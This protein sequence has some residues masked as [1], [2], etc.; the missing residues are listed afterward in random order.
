MRWLPT[1]PAPPVTSATFGAG[2]SRALGAHGP[3]AN[4][5]R[6]L[7]LGSRGMPLDERLVDQFEGDGWVVL[8]GVLDAD[9]IDRA[10]DALRA[11]AAASEARG[12]PTAMDYLDPGGRNVRV[13][14]L[15]EYR[16]VFVDLVAHPG[17]IP[18]VAR[19]L[20]DDLA[21]SNFSANIALPGS[22]SMNAHND[23]STVMPEPWI[24]PVHDERDLVP[25]RHRRGQRRHPLPA[26]QPP[27]H[28]LRRGP[29]RPEGRHARLRGAGR[30][31]DPHGRSAVAHL[32]R[33]HDRPTGSGRCCS[34]STPARSCATRTTGTDR[35]PRTPG[36]DSTRSLKEWLGLGT[37]NMGYGTYLAHP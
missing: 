32:R 28:L 30:F 23:Q 20:D 17:V 25:R 37:G 4:R 13:Y 16:P 5:P 36:A 31:G 22:R 1:N 26:G 7:P 3:E 29:G 2:R 18:Y 33:E 24:D 11:A 12:I 35:C 21:V 10:L 34:R 8:P 15:I 9:E 14:D 27:V 19:L 6:M